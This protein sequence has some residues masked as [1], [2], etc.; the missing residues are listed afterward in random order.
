MTNNKVKRSKK[1]TTSVETSK[2]QSTVLFDDSIEVS[3]DKVVTAL[4]KGLTDTK[5]AIIDGVV[6]PINVSGASELPL[7]AAF[8]TLTTSKPELIRG[9]NFVGLAYTLYIA[10]MSTLQMKDYLSNKLPFFTKFYS[11]SM[12]KNLDT[13]LQCLI[14]DLVKRIYSFQDLLLLGKAYLELIYKGNIQVY[15]MLLATMRMFNISRKIF[16]D[17]FIFQVSNQQKVIEQYEDFL[18]NFAKQISSSDSVL[19]KDDVEE[20]SSL[21]HEIE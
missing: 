6:I 9:V 14:N 18:S 16:N 21:T 19:S 15:K 20:L 5:S 2:E 1:N 4:H 13:F 11:P 12:M 17:T 7:L 8:A 10:T 3:F